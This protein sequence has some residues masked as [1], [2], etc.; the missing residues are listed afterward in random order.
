MELL[1]LLGSLAGLFKVEASLVKAGDITGIK[2]NEVTAIKTGDISI[3][4]RLREINIS[5]V[6]K[7]NR[8]ENL[9]LNF[10]PIT[11]QSY[12]VNLFLSSPDH[13]RRLFNI[14]DEKENNEQ[15]S[16]VNQLASGASNRTR[17][18]ALKTGTHL[19]VNDPELF[20]NSQ[21]F[22][23][24][25]DHTL[26]PVAADDSEVIIESVLEASRKIG[27]IFQKSVPTK[28]SINWS[29]ERIASISPGN[30]LL[31]GNSEWIFS[32]LDLG[33]PIYL[34]SRRDTILSI[35]GTLVSSAWKLVRV[36]RPQSTHEAR[37]T[38]HFIFLTRRA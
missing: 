26:I 10:I 7:S 2:A 20:Q 32:S 13:L 1:T 6:D 14:S 11:N 15:S 8:T 34:D 28:L 9:T 16:A 5:A 18:I 38:Q 25:E 22:P 29:S 27:V 23:V 30:P 24:N 31:L 36:H 33:Q 37:P 4:S 21:A 3:A 17:R 35:D 12:Q 19:I